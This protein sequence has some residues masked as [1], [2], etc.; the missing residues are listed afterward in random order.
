VGE[1][2]RP[3]TFLATLVCI[4]AVAAAW[5]AVPG[6]FGDSG[7]TVVRGVQSPPVTSG[8]CFDAGVIVSYT[9]TGGLIGC[10]YV[11]TFV[12]TGAQP[13]GTIQASGTEHFVGCLDLGGDG[14][15]GVG[16]PAGT[17]S[18]TFTFTAKYDAAGNEIHGRCHHPIISG[19][20]GFA[21]VTG[22]IEFTDDVTTGTSDYT[23]TIGL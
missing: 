19:T 18:T 14:T 4:F 3:K 5:T 11:D 2:K 17:F 10:W 21:G 12:L 15:C 8:P 6:A 20:G 23:G 7:A 9:M 16:D 1:V 13:S 22:V